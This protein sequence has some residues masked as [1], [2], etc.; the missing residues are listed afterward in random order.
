M[1]PYVPWSSYLAGWTDE[2]VPSSDNDCVAGR[3]SCLKATLKEPST[4]RPGAWRGSTKTKS[5]NDSLGFSD[6]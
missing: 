5:G 1:L 3:P 4:G 6:G 2:Y